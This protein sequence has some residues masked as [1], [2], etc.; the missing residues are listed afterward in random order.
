MAL[1]F[2]D[3]INFIHNRSSSCTIK[4]FP[5][6]GYFT[7]L[8]NKR[9][10]TKQFKLDTSKLINKIKANKN[11]SYF[12]LYLGCYSPIQNILAIKYI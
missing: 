12:S 7:Y 10:K 11:D 1:Y 9:L 8:F 6:N 4:K 2:N 3:L 5:I